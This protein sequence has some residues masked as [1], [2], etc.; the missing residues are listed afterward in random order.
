M[1]LKVKTAVLQ[2]MVAKAIKGAGNNKLIPITSLMSFRVVG[3]ELQ[4]ITTDGTNYLVIK[5]PITD[6]TDFEEVVIPTEIA[7]LLA[8]L[9]KEYTVFTL[10]NGVLTVV[11]N[12]EY[13]V[14]LSLDE[15]GEPIKYPLPLPSED[16]IRKK[17][18]IEADTIRTIYNVCSASVAVTLENPCYTGYYMGA[19]R[20]ITTNSAKMAGIDVDV[21][22]GEDILISP[23]MMKLFEVVDNK[24]ITASITNDN[25]LMFETETCTIY[26]PELY[27]IE[28]YDID[29]VSSVFSAEFSA[30]CELPKTEL[31]ALLDRVSLFVG[32]YENKAIR[33][34]F[35]KDHIDVTSVKSNARETLGYMSEIDL[36]EPVECMVDVTMWLE[37]LK[38]HTAESV[39][40]H[41]GNPIAIKMTDNNVT[42][43][44]ALLTD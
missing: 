27:G 24:K 4:I 11:S 22:G 28:D 25:K 30:V 21:F 3:K 2:S 40:V 13:K 41:F 23:E 20:V 16:N 38:A 19:D 43:I 7:K 39:M 15:N 10:E 36:A 9:T 18:E 17:V 29:A 33:L 1:K 35:D 6:E 14:E 12:G 26:G 37:Q 44:L 32:E 8:R 42:Q 34:V 31:L 5:S